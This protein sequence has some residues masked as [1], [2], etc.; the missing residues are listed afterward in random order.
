M[1]LFIIAAAVAAASSVIAQSTVEN[2][3]V[4]PPAP[5]PKAPMPRQRTQQPGAP[6]TAAANAKAAN[7][8][9]DTPVVT[10][11][12]ICQDK[13][14]KSPCKTVVTREDLDRYIGA[15][16]PD[17]SA[18]GRSRAAI[19]YA[20][21][22][23]F[24]SLA[25]QL[26][27]DKNPTLAKELE[28]Q[29]KLLRMRILA[30]AFL[31]N[32]EQ[33]TSTIVQSQVERYYELHRDEYEEARVQRVAIPLLV[34]TESR[35]PPDRETVK[36]EMEALRTR[37]AA[38]D[39]LNQ[40]LH[41]AFAHLHIQAAPPPVNT[42]TIRQNTLQGEEAKAFDLKPGEI[43]PV[44]DTA[45]SF[46]IYKMESKEP[47]PIDSLRPEIENALH[48]DLVQ[49]QVSKVG[50]RVTTQFNLEYLELASQPDIFGPAALNPAPNRTVRPRPKTH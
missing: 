31:Q 49:N 32:L 26:G 48:Q 28:L 24:S 42:M 34:P 10:M 1:R 12:G 5:L 47:L 43:T 29:L 39:D 16:A 6:A 9:P 18:A 11:E 37:A 46:A 36:A 41:D 23:A 40:L 44:I 50:K 27:L 17:T 7:V 14:A 13:Q 22:V 45:A 21:T 15:S 3:P 2:S 19:Q 20:R 33:Q 25:D 8:P 4:P 38:G 30:T 35:R